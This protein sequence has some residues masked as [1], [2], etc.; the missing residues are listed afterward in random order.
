MIG[1]VSG[2]GMRAN[3]RAHVCAHSLVQC[4]DQRMCCRQAVHRLELSGEIRHIVHLTLSLVLVIAVVT[5][6]EGCE[7]SSSFA[8]PTPYP[9]TDRQAGTH[10]HRERHTEREREREKQIQRP[11]VSHGAFVVAIA[12][13]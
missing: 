6:T 9:Q 12:C 2:H 5:I 13:S 11:M 7:A 1:C 3:A 10:T 4:E 8:V